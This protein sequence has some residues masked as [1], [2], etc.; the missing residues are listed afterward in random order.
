MRGVCVKRMGVDM[1][2]GTLKDGK[3]EYEDDERGN[4]S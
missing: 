4:E 3:R 2:N 1:T